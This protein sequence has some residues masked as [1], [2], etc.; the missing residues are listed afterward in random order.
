VSEDPYSIL[1]V[2]RRATDAE[3]ERAYERLLRLFDPEHYP[4]S[5]E[6]AS[7]RLDELN[8][9]YAQIRNEAAGEDPE[10]DE[11]G[12]AMREPADRRAAIAES[13]A[14]LGFIPSDG[15]HRDN[16]A[17]DVLAT[18]LPENAAVA[19]CL[20]CLG[21]RSSGQYKFRERSGGFR[22]MTVARRDTPYAVSDYVHPI[23]RTEIVFCTD[24]ELSW[25]VS[26]YA[27]EGRDRVALY[28]LPFADVLG[29]EVRGR[30]RDVVDVWIDDGPTVSIRTRP[31]GA[32]ALRE[33]IERAATS[34]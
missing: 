6:D 26:Q 1:G 17:V 9:A 12:E 10:P 3:I 28:S 20:T 22:A 4:G 19:V 32:D 21:V 14:R 23:E 11:S 16:P 15:R 31:R 5:T 7:R 33:C 27:G 13:L 34:P 2:S 24:D 29:A 25:T 30:K 18:L 8:A